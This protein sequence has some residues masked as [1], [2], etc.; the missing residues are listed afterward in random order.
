LACRLFMTRRRLASSSANCG[1]YAMLSA[2]LYYWKT[3]ASLRLFPI[4]ICQSR[5]SSTA[6]MLKVTAEPCSICTTSMF[7]GGMADLRCL[8]T[9]KR[10]MVMPSE[11]S[12]SEAATISRDSTWIPIPVSLL[13]RFGRPPLTLRR[14]SS[15]CAPS[16]SNSR[17]PTT[18]GLDPRL[19]SANWNACTNWPPP[20]EWKPRQPVLADFQQALADLTASPRV[21]I[22]ARFDPALLKRKYE[23]TERE[24]LR[25]VAIVNS[26]GMECAC[27]VYRANRLAPL[28]LNIPQTC[29]ALG[30]E[31]RAVVSEF[32]DEF[33]E[34]NVHF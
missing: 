25:L 26:K 9:L 28:A 24:W 8:S 19:S 16:P 32:W 21:C 3:E 14:V 23:L 12:I 20:A 2:A 13:R 17:K 29:K 34:T 6:C 33:P 11:K 4:W 7:A 31:L 15:S 22:D 30:S 5:N 18:N 1:A 10:S 27:I